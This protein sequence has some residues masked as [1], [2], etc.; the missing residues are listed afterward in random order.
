LLGLACAALPIAVPLAA[1]AAGMNCERAAS[2]TEKA[3]CADPELLER[4]SKLAESYAKVLNADPAQS[5]AVRQSQRAWLQVRNRCGAN[6]ACL[7]NAFDERSAALSTQF[8]IASAYQ[9]DEVDKQAAEDLRAAVAEELKKNP[10]FPLENALKRFAIA[11]K[12][13][14]DFAN[15]AAPDSSD[16]AEFPKQRPKGVSADEWKALQASDLVSESENGH[17]SY[18]LIDLD[19]DGKRDL[20]ID[21]Y[22]GGTGLFNYISNRRRIGGK[23][24]DGKALYSLNGRG[25]NQDGTWVRLRDRIYAAYRVGAYGEDTVYL[26][27]ALKSVG[28]TPAVTVHYRY[29]LKVPKVQVSDDGKKS[30][31]LDDKTHVA[32]S[33]ALSL[34]EGARESEPASESKPICPIPAGTSE[35]DSQSYYTLGPGHYTFEIVADFP[36]QLNGVCHVGRLV[37]WFGGY[38]EKG[39]LFAQ[40][41]IGRPGTTDGEAKTYGV[42]GKRTATDVSTTVKAVEGDN[43]A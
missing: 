43:G 32:L 10:E 35:D 39:G 12:D 18:S 4:D 15:V 16:P 36:V 28:Q 14:T 38:S 21:D 2:V 11:P 27:R 42:T 24:E 9:P 1:H 6:Q 22:I 33:K 23:F 13:T 17:S 30:T 37:D 29:D 19:G 7:L 8:Q 34:V 40:Y 31:T 5:D 3:I 41:S 26:M 20:I 25:A